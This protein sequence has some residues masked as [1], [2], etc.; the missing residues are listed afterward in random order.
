MIPY[1]LQTQVFIVLA[2]VTLYK[3]IRQE[4]RQDL[5]FEKYSNIEM[6]VIDCSDEDEDDETVAGFY[7]ITPRQLDGLVQGQFR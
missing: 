3:Y 1:S 7:V 2:T 6:I 4:A 5:L